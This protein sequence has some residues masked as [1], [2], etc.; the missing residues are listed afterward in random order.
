MPQSTT[1]RQYEIVD[2][3]ALTPVACP[4]GWARRALMEAND[5]PISVHQTDISADARTHYHRRLTES[6]YILECADDARMELDGEQVPLKPGQLVLI[7]PGVRHRAIGP[8]RVLVIVSPK[9][10]PAD[11][12]FD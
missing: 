12:W 11:E 5:V 4:C 6:Y 2:F 10:E 9:F 3:A 1:Q 8:M 7:R